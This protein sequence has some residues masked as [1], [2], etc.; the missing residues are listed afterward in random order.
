M[1]IIVTLDVMMAKWKLS[2]KELA[3]AIEFTEANLSLLKWGKSEGS[4]FRD[5]GGDLQAPGLP[6]REYSGVCVRAQDQGG[7]QSHFI[8]APRTLVCQ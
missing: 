6:A 1:E 8:N 2:S 4:A 7:A 3:K 5:A